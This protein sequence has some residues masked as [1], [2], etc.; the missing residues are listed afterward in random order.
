MCTNTKVSVQGKI[1]VNGAKRGLLICSLNAPSILKH[2]DE[3]D[4]LIRDN[5]ID[6]LAINETKLDNRVKDETVAI[7]DYCLKRFD[8]NRHGGGVAVYI[9]EALNFEHRIDFPM[10]N[11]ETI[12]TEVK[13]NCSKPFFVLAWYRPP[14]YETDTLTEMETLLRAVESEKKRNYID[15]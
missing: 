7:S 6:I 10:G 13:P 2:K 14:K 15:R 4:T 9:R 12:C 1:R 3:I 8:R 5:K 11:L